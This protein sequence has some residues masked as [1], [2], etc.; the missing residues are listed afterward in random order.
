M[1]APGINSL[2]ALDYYRMAE[3][4]ARRDEQPGMNE[5]FD[6]A[7]V[8]DC[9][10]TCGPNHSGRFD[11]RCVDTLVRYQRHSRHSADRS[12][13]RATASPLILFS[14]RQLR[15]PYWRS[16]PL[17]ITIPGGKPAYISQQVV[18]PL[19]PTAASAGSLL[20]PARSRACVFPS[21]PKPSLERASPHPRTEDRSGAVLSSHWAHPL[22]GRSTLSGDSWLPALVWGSRCSELYTTVTIIEPS[23]QGIKRYHIPYAR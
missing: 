12:R 21:H 9:C 23:G 17:R 14:S 20:S 15:Q 5:M 7:P 18:H 19:P 1:E 8:P 4:D 3:A 10:A 22:L 11:H 6:G 2:K 16:Q 13:A